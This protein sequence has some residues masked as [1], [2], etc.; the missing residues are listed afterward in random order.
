MTHQPGPKTP[1]YINP[2][3]NFKGGRDI[4]HTV[5]FQKEDKMRK[6]ALYTAKA[7]KKKENNNYLFQKIG[8]ED[9][10]KETLAQ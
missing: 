8:E 3:N 6:Q 9:M 5:D 1:G 2:T 7:D 4:N 10:K